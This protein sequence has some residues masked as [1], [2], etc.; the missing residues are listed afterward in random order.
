MTDDELRAR[1]IA[2]LHQKSALWRTVGGFVLGNMLMVAI[3]ALS[4]GG[5]FWPVWT[6][7][8][9]L[10]AVAPMAWHVYGPTYRGPSAARIDAEMDRLRNQP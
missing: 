2:S 9:G 10:F 4:G 5:Y 7:I 6:I 3:W 1:A 8:A